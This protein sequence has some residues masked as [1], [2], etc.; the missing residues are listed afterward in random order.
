[1]TKHRRAGTSDALAA[2]GAET[3]R[4]PV[5]PSQTEGLPADCCLQ[6]YRTMV[7]ARALEEQLIKISTS[8]EGRI[9]VGR[10]EEDK[11]ECIALFEQQLRQAKLLDDETTASIW[12]AAEAEVEAAL[13]QALRE[14]V[15][16]CISQSVL[17]H[18]RLARMNCSQ[19]LDCSAG[20]FP[21]E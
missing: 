16:G 3:D 13:L 14:F 19:P 6:I 1:M 11:P 10:V 17:G 15:T 12:G 21:G 4:V 9:W 5:L 20:R 8:G 7:R 18:Q 2:N